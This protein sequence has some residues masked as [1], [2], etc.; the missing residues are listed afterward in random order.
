[1]EHIQPIE[2]L[3]PKDKTEVGPEQPNVDSL[4]QH[5]Q[6]LGQSKGILQQA[7][8][9]EGEL[10]ILTELILVLADMRPSF[11]D[12][13]LELDRVLILPLVNLLQE[14]LVQQN[15]V[16]AVASVHPYN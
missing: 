13:I 15:I 7:Y 4:L 10:K 9:E 12:Q 1:M 5:M 3:F 16:L 14:L 2:Y 11:K 8:V 6:V